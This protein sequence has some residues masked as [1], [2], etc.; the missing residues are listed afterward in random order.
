MCGRFVLTADVPELM[1][2]YQMKETYFKEGTSSDEEAPPPRYNIAP[3]HC[4]FTV[5]VDKTGARRLGRVRWGIRL[6]WRKEKLLINIRLET[7][8][9]TPYF[10]KLLST[11]RVIV[12]MQAFYE[13]KKGTHPSQPYLIRVADTADT[14]IFSVGAL[15]TKNEEGET[16][17]ALL[18]K[19][20]ENGLDTLHPRMPLLL[21]HDKEKI[22]LDRT[23]T[24]VDAFR[25]LLHVAPADITFYPVSTRVNTST[26]DEPELILPLSDETV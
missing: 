16:Q 15:W 25:S 6:P 2:R 23:I 20:A 10:Q 1:R 21:P 5:A 14:D 22:W 9:T 26:I 17:L 8:L 13:W 3:T 12:P 19:P 4:I 11:R 24:D 18:T 7:A